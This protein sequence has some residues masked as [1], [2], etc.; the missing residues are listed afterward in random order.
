RRP[1]IVLEVEEVAPHEV[2]HLRVYDGLVDQRAVPAQ[3]VMHGPWR[4]RHDHRWHQP[5]R[6]QLQARH[7]TA[8]IAQRLAS[9]VELAQSTD[10]LA[11]GQR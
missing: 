3:H 11:R 8:G 7:R 10:L 1:V 4:S 9:G 5:A 2:S 6:R